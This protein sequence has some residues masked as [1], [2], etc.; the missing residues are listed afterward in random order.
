MAKQTD[1]MGYYSVIK[2]NELPSHK[3]T[4]RKL[5][6][7]SLSERSQHENAHYIYDFNYMKQ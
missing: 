5:K 1:I 4:W 2:R 3:K 7:V 6:S